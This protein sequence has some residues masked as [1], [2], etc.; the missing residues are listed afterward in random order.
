MTMERYCPSLVNYGWF[1]PA[2][3]GWM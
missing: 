2:I 1:T 3:F